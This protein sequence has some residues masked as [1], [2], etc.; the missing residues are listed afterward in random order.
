MILKGYF[1]ISISSEGGADQPFGRNLALKI[2]GNWRGGSGFGSLGKIP[3]LASRLSF[4]G[5]RS[6]FFT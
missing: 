2:A 6:F 3:N 4:A 1:G 5:P